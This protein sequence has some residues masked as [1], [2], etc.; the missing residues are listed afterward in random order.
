MIIRSG[1]PHPGEIAKERLFTSA[2]QSGNGAASRQ[3]APT[4]EAER[5]EKKTTHA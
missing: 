2:S 5:H 3:P 1:A 4:R